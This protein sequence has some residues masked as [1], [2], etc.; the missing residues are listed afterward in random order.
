MVSDAHGKPYRA[1]HSL[2]EA[3][4]DPDGTVIL[5]GDWGGT[6]FATCPARLVRCDQGLDQL[7]HDVNEIVWP[8]QPEGS[9]VYYERLP[10]GSG[11]PGGG[12][13]GVVVE[14]V[15]VHD[16]FEELGM[17]EEIREVIMGRTRRITTHYQ[18]VHLVVRVDMGVDVGANLGDE[19]SR[20]R[21]RYRVVH[22]V[23]SPEEAEAE[24]ARLRQW[25]ADPT[26]TYF[27][28]WAPLKLRDEDGG[29]S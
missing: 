13:G 9:R 17:A 11:V 6:I 22:I 16:E 20:Y 25:D 29:R 3:R 8:G 15:W 4:A 27:H 18:R 10:I 12:A 14:G 26:H 24:V 21:M 2:G 28:E 5:E 19:A 23:W 1:F 7:L